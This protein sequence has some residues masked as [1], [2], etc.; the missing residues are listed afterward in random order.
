MSRL[1][2]AIL[3]SLIGLVTIFSVQNA[4]TVEIQFL[5]WKL[6]LPRALLFMVI[7]GSGVLIGLVMG[8]IKTLK[9]K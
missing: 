4:A 5:L 3:L 8:S 9:K 2:A 1:K 7:L 6:S